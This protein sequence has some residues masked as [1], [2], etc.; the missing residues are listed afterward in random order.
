M[1]G[2]YCLRVVAPVAWDIV[3]NSSNFSE[4]K[5]FEDEKNKSC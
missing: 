3:F 5:Q 2:G 4:N 1:M